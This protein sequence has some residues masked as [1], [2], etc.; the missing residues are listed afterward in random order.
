MQKLLW[1]VVTVSLLSACGGGEVAPALQSGS[2]SLSS[3]TPP[4][5]LPTGTDGHRIVISAGNNQTNSFNISPDPNKDVP[6]FK[7]SGGA[8]NEPFLF[9][10]ST[11]NGSVHVSAIVN[12]TGGRP[13]DLGAR[14][15]MD[16]TTVPT[17]GFASYL[18]GY[19]GFLTRGDS[20]TRPGLTESY[21]SGD[22]ILNADFAA[23]I[24]D[25]SIVNRTRYLTSN[26]TALEAA[27]D[28]ALGQVSIENGI[29]RTDGL[30]SGGEI[31][32]NTSSYVA[33]G[34]GLRGSWNVVFGGP[35]AIDAVGTLQ[36]DHDY[37]NGSG[38]T[39]DDYVETGGF[40]ATK[41]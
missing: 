9:K 18:G 17:A 29:T 12:H 28:I 27:S 32:P 4:V 2:N 25:G 6:A 16:I 11:S 35:D 14:A 21:F 33:Q 20:T 26:G 5:I 13:A 15:T 34:S 3:G 41:Q 10:S 22:V 38:Q 37:Q 39:Q 8:A 36:I 1:V 30:T 24:V 7:A 19:A 40:I 23:G 31:F